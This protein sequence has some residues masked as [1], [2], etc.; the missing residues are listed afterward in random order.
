MKGNDGNMWIIRET[1]NGV[2]RWIKFNNK[3]NST[4]KSKKITETKQK[5]KTV[6]GPKNI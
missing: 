5:T 6:K 1:K 3:S 4:K 2:K